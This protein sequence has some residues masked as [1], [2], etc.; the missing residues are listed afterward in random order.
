[1]ETVR[2]RWLGRHT[3]ATVCSVGLMTLIP[4]ALYFGL[5]VWSGDL[6]GPLNLVIV[7]G[8]GAVIGFLISLLMFLPLGMLAEKSNLL[9]WCR[10]VGFVLS[11][12]I[13]IVA[14]T[15]VWFGTAGLKNRA[16]LFS[17]MVAVYVISGFFAYLCGLTIG[18][19]L[20]GRSRLTG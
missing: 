19:R 13:I 6:G 7:P 5:I 10:N 11:G 20:W 14:L 9:S 15:W 4:T 17:G 16:Y 8:V 12:S 18:T 1:M 3:L 2:L